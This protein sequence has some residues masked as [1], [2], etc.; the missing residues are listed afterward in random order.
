MIIVAGAYSLLGQVLV[1]KLNS[2]NFNYL[3][4]TDDNHLSPELLVNNSIRYWRQL[5]SSDLVEW[6]ANSAEEIECI[7]WCHPQLISSKNKT[8]SSL[9]KLGFLHQIPFIGVVSIDQNINEYLDKANSP[10]YWALLKIN[11]MYSTSSLMSVDENQKIKNLATHLEWMQ[12]NNSKKI[13]L[14]WAGDVANVIYHFIRSR[15]QTGIFEIPYQN[16]DVDLNQ[17]KITVT[18]LMEKNDRINHS[19]V[20]KQKL[21][22]IGYNEAFTTIEEFFPDNFSKLLVQLNS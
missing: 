6:V 21:S 9:W 11:F 15:K 16:I 19:Q 14:T 20:I 2:E 12:L 7:I 5:A 1:K 22:E 3:V 17:G 8:V 4:L 13:A 18:P 10:F